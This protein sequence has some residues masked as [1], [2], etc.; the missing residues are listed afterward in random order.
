MAPAALQGF[1]ALSSGLCGLG[2]CRVPIIRFCWFNVVA[3]RRLFH[4]FTRVGVWCLK[5]SQEVG[6][7]EDAR[8]NVLLTVFAFASP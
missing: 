6:V 2:S 8:G 4:G 7:G 1:E 5:L 3:Y